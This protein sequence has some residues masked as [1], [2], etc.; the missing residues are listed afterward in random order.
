MCCVG[1]LYESLGKK[2]ESECFV[3]VVLLCLLTFWSCLVLLFCLA[4]CEG[5]AVIAYIFGSRS[6]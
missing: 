3:V 2:V 5:G 6:G 1:L 4:T